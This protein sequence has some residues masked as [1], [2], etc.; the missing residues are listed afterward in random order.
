MTNVN[1]STELATTT[2]DTAL[3][4]RTRA[5]ALA[6]NPQLAAQTSALEV[7]KQ[8]AVILLESHLLPE[9]IKTWQVAAA[10]MMRAEELEV[11]YWVGLIHLNA[12]KGAPQPDGQLC[13]ALIQRSE[14]LE[15][16]EILETTDEICSIRM[17]RRG[18]PAF[19]VICTMKEYEKVM[20]PDG[21]RQPKTHLF[22]YTYKQGARRLFSDVLNNMQPK[23]TMRR[24]IVED[25]LQADLPNDDVYVIEEGEDQPT[26]TLPLSVAP[27]AVNVS[28]ASANEDADSVD[29]GV[30][31]VAQAYERFELGGEYP[32]LGS[33]DMRSLQ[34]RALRSGLADNEFHFANLLKQMLADGTIREGATSDKVLDAMRKHKAEKEFSAREDERAFSMGMTGSVEP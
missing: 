13:M 7:L 12:I 3:A 18:Q 28:S 21:R 23:R 17:K 9:S 10:I 33:L 24:V 14:L 4:V 19:D 29:K 22:W 20:G 34:E 11:D 30:L 2:E 1:E 31:M 26:A 5:E 15:R 16:Y 27:S 25:D 6:A 32:P 8:K